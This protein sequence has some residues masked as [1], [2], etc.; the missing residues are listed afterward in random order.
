MTKTS[1]LITVIIGACWSNSKCKNVQC[2]RLIASMTEAVGQ[3]TISNLQTLRWGHLFLIGP[4]T[5]MFSFL[6]YCG[7]SCTFAQYIWFCEYQPC[8]NVILTFH[9]HFHM[10]FSSQFSQRFTLHQHHMHRL[11]ALRHVNCFNC[12]Y[13][14]WWHLTVAHRP[15]TMLEL[16]DAQAQKVCSF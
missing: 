6:R 12:F 14:F 5:T 7:P 8:D 2:K 13:Y 4:Y 1:N 3:Q 11:H 16:Y 10:T 15:R 9:C